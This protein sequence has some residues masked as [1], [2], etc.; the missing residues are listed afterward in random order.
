MANIPIEQLSIEL[1][2]KMEQKEI[3]SILQKNN[4]CFTFLIEFYLKKV[5]L[6]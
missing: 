5:I 1:R 2:F 4:G 3:T 6:K